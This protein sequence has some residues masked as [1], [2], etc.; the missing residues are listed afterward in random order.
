MPRIPKK[1]V[2]EISFILQGLTFHDVDGNFRPMSHEVWR[3]AHD[4]LKEHMSLKYIY[5]YI[6]ENR[7]G[8]LKKLYGDDA[9][10]GKQGSVQRNQSP[11]IL[12]V[13]TSS[14]WSDSGFTEAPS[15]R[16][17]LCLSKDTWAKI[18]PGKIR[19]GQRIYESLKPGWTSILYEEIWAQLK[20]PCCYSFKHGR[21]NKN[22][23]FY[24]TVK[25]SCAECGAPFHAYILDEPDPLEKVI[26]HLSTY[27]TT[28]IQHDK[29]RQLR[30]VER[31]NAVKD[32]QGSSTYAWRREKAQKTMKFRDPSQLIYIKNPH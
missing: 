26:L 22:D 4:R 17:I 7:N 3:L 25:G 1:S 32:L 9:P 2:D 16:T 23:K 31:D 27:D 18:N 21:I 20:I 24:L 28:N 14:N 8:I 30:G 5:L 19:I 12:N 6:T 11:K 29:K 15:I 10:I 13:S